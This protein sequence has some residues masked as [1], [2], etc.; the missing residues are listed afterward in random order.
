M[1]RDE[2]EILEEG[3]V[4]TSEKALRRKFEG[5]EPTLVAF[6]VGTHSRWISQLL[7][8]LGHEVIV[9]NARK[10]R[11][12]CASEIK[13]D[14]V[15]ARVLARLA[16]ADPNLLYPIEHR[17]E[18]AQEH[19]AVVHGRDVLIKVRTQLINHVRG[20]AKSFGRR[21]TKCDADYFHLRIPDEIPKGLRL[22][23]Q[24]LILQVCSLT[25]QIKAYDK[26]IERLCA[27]YAETELFTS[28]PGVG[29]VTALAFALIVEEPYRFTKNRNVAC[30][31]GLVPR[32]DQSGDQNPQLR[33]TKAGNAYMRRLLVTAGQSVLKKTSKQDSELRRWGLNLAGPLNTKGKHNKRLKKRAVVA[34]ARKLA[35]LLLVMWK[36]GE[37]YD[38]FYHEH[39]LQEK[40]GKACAA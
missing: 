9:A 5:M 11:L 12:I 1:E 13:N 21:L 23:L 30:H 37:F 16:R 20:K 10:V 4:M 3:V 7:K 19:L 25:E 8:S 31:F 17:G 35:I 26:E 14:K 28:V 18:Q 38:T 6:E 22:A 29:P 36:T 39:K 32:Q 33:I 15:D 27:E 40:K 34:V 2:D 24:P